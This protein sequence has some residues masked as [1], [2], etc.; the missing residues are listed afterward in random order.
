MQSDYRSTLCEISFD[1]DLS[2]I[3]D[4]TDVMFL[5]R[6]ALGSIDT[7]E[8]FKQTHDSDARESNVR[9]CQKRTS[10]IRARTPPGPATGPYAYTY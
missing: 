7:L 1:R 9:G 6:S 10:L 4:L 5:L 8:R 3:Q 2:Y